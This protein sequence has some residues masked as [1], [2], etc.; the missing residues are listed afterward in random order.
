MEQGELQEQE[1]IVYRREAETQRGLGF[2]CRPDNRRRAFLFCEDRFFI[3]LSFRPVSQESPASTGLAWP[4]RRWAGGSREKEAD[5]DRRLSGSGCL[6]GCWGSLSGR[7]ACAKPLPAAPEERLARRVAAISAGQPAVQLRAGGPAQRPRLVATGHK[8]TMRSRP[9][10]VLELW[11]Q[12]C[13][14]LEA[15]PR[16]LEW[17]VRLLESNGIH[18]L[19]WVVER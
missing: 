11:L 18:P 14:H 16:R 15:V 19:E 7:F 13:A 4:G 1:K 12:R 9:T 2:E 6:L 5:G 3:L 17:A 10:A 8:E